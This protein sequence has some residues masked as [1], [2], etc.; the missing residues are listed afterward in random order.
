MMVQGGA[1]VQ[2][3]RAQLGRRIRELRTEHR[4][5]QSYL[6]ERAGMDQ[7][8]LARVERGERWPSVPLLFRLADALDADVATLF[9]A[10]GAGGTPARDEV[11]LT[12]EDATADQQVLVRDV[13]RLLR[14][15]WRNQDVEKP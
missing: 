15:S 5:T 8:H 9:R 7:A 12:L 2:E 6:A 13:V 4:F 10:G 14:S 11:L 1:S 3:R